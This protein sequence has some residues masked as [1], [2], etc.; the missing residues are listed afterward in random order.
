MLFIMNRFV[1]ILF[2]TFILFSCDHNWK[3]AV[4]SNESD[5][6]VSF[7]FS[8]VNGEYS[9]SVSESKRF[10]SY[11]HTHLEYYSPDKRVSYSH[12]SDYN[13][14]YGTFKNLPSWTLRVFNNLSNP[15]TLT[16]GGWME[17]MENISHGDTDDANHTGVIFTK[18]LLFAAVTNTG[19]IANVAY[20]I[21]NDVIY[22][23]IN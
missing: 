8:N 4:I 2:F 16:A 13:G 18:E 21:V 1:F 22:V 9:L 6:P 14:F 15:V 5:Y 11:W 10:D 3:Y 19:F 23:T 17:P 12:T 20:H 7:K